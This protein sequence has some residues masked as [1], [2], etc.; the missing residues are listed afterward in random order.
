[1]L[2][3]YM[4]YYAQK[5]LNVMLNCLMRAIY[6][7]SCIYCGNSSLQ[8]VEKNLNKKCTN[9]FSK[10]PELVKFS[11]D[12]YYPPILACCLVDLMFVLFLYPV[13]H[14]STACVEVHNT[15]ILHLECSL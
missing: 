10:N 15:T 12:S 6:L 4:N 14:F 11:K 13:V 5:K 3:I 1:M 8:G 2:D 9:F 7:A